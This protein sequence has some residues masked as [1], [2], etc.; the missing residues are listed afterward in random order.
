MSYIINYIS[1]TDAGL[2]KLLREA[3]SD[4]EDGNITIKQKLQKIAKV[5][6]NGN[7][8]SAQEAVYYCLSLPLFLK[9]VALVYV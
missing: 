1:K 3:A 5:F 8:M 6:I 7:L 9:V 4:I 2:S